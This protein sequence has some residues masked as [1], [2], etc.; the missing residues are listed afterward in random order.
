MIRRNDTN[1]NGEVYLT[2][3]ILVSAVKKGIR[4]AAEE[5]M[6]IQGYNVIAENGWVVRVYA[7]GRREPIKELPAIVRPKHITLR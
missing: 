2:K 1:A 7:D 5:T 4:K 3:R 6:S